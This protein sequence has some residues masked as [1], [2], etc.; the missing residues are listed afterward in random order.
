MNNQAT[1]FPKIRNN[2]GCF[3]WSCV[4]CV[5]V[6]VGEGVG[7]AVGVA[8]GVR[9]GSGV[10]GVAVVGAEEITC[11]VGETEGGWDAVALLVGTGVGV[12]VGAT[13]ELLLLLLVV[14]AWLSVEAS[15]GAGVTVGCGVLVGAL[16]ILAALLSS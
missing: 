3:G 13:D 11:A 1:V 15:E 7:L 2:D 16:A 14:G 9:V 12:S 5:G 4:G 10:V 8:V 6:A